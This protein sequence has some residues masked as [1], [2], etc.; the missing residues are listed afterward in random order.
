METEDAMNKS[1]LLPLTLVILSNIPNWGCATKTL[2]IKTSGTAAVSLIQPSKPDDDGVSLGDTPVTLTLD[3]AVGRVI[4]VSQKGKVPVYWLVS[5]AVGDVT[6]AELKLVDEPVVEK[7]QDKNNAERV[8]PRTT[9]NRIMRLILRSY[10]ALTGNR[11]SEAK[12][13]ADQAAAIDPQ[14]A[15][16][17][18][19]KGLAFYQEGKVEDARTELTKA[20]ALDPEDKDIDTLIKKVR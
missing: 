8:D 13:L 16:P 18:V 12:Q 10:Q 5:D 15:A 3:R 19:I 11:L 4:K 14:I 2:K 9:N 17:H 1:R 20:Q 6:T 7:G